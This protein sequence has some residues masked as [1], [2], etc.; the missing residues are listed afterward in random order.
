[1]LAHNKNWGVTYQT[2]G[3]HMS[4]PTGYLVGVVKLAWYSINITL[5]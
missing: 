5:L 3:N 2:D 1:M 4:K